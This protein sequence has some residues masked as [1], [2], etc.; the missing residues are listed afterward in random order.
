MFFSRTHTSDYLVWEGWLPELWLVSSSQMLGIK[1]NAFLPLL[2]GCH[3]H[4]NLARMGEKTIFQHLFCDSSWWIDSLLTGWFR[5]FSLFLGVWWQNSE[6]MLTADVS[7]QVNVGI[8]WSEIF[9]TLRAKLRLLHLVDLF[10][11]IQKKVKLPIRNRLK[12]SS[13]Q[14]KTET[15]FSFISRIPAPPNRRLSSMETILLHFS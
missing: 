10:K 8:F 4:I 6:E 9:G 7:S 12:F 1:G 11:V 5:R 3:D 2:H 13:C 15:D 14:S